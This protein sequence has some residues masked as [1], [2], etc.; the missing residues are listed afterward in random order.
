MN[1]P[2]LLLNV[3]EVKECE[4]NYGS[5]NVYKAVKP[6]KVIFNKCNGFEFRAAVFADNYKACS[7]M[8]CYILHFGTCTAQALRHVLP[9]TGTD[10]WNQDTNEAYLVQSRFSEEDLVHLMP[11]LIAKVKRDVV[12]QA[13]THPKICLSSIHSIVLV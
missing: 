10:G 6:T 5:W 7:F 9:L 8:H 1:V 2:I 12:P 11:Y 3:L 4:Q 13:S